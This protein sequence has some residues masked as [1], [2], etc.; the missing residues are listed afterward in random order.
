MSTNRRPELAVASGI[1][2]WLLAGAGL[3]G[4][5]LVEA[6]TTTMIV[7]WSLVAV[8]TLAVIIAQVVER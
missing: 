4:W 7:A 2:V 1:A 5:R 6:I 8:I 3:L